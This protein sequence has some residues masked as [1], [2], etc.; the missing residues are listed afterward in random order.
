VKPNHQPKFRRMSNF[1]GVLD[2]SDDEHPSPRPVAASSKAPEPKA[3]VAEPS[4]VAPLANRSRKSNDDRSGRGGRAPSR[5]GK[6]AYDRRSGTGRGR[7]IKKGGGGARNWGS[8]KNDARSAEHAATEVDQEEAKEVVEIEANVSGEPSQEEQV[9]VVEELQVEQE[10]EDNTL[11]LDE[12]LKKKAEDHKA[13]EAFKALSVKELVV[14]ES[15]ATK[16]AFKK[17]QEDFLVMGE[18]KKPK[19]KVSTKPKPEKQTLDVD[20]KVGAPTN[21]GASA[22]RRRETDGRG[23]SDFERSG[24]RGGEGRRGGGRGGGR[25]EGGRGGREGGRGNSSFSGRGGRDFSSSRGPKL[26]VAD[27]TAFPSL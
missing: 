7:E 2:D 9:H 25:Y 5:E 21:F 19:K 17:E 13:S 23:R 12:Y 6:R 14:D 27:T 16:S 18:T 11:T 4:T 10:E 20:F 1:F 24:G 22:G 3:P 26:D 15:F 8:D